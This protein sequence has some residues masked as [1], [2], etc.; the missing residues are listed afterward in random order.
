M[1]LLESCDFCE[2]CS[3]FFT[4]KQQLKS[5]MFTHADE[6]HKCP[7][8]WNKKF[9]TQDELNDHLSKNKCKGKKEVL[10]PQCG[11]SCASKQQLKV[12]IRNTHED[13]VYRFQ[14]T[15]CHTLYLTLSLM[16][17]HIRFKHKV[18][19]DSGR[20]K[21]FYHLYSR[22]DAK[23]LDVAKLNASKPKGRGKTW[24]KVVQPCP[25]G[26]GKSYTKKS[27]RNH[28]KT[29][30]LKAEEDYED[31]SP[32]NPHDYHYSFPLST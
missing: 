6:V 5:H 30:E 20:Q 18:E 22:E 10:C 12:H 32:Y 23:M 3:D 29:C 27:M 17:Q 31:G 14:C 1:N 28:R 21:D 8:C 24:D 7:T 4:N 13:K 25:N 26:C 19:K 11:K 15:V 16:K 9:F 2:H